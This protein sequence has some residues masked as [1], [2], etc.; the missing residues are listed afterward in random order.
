MNNK[1]LALIACRPCK[2]WGLREVDARHRGLQ[3]PIAILCPARRCRCSTQAP[4]RLVAGHIAAA[5]V[6]PSWCGAGPSRQPRPVAGTGPNPNPPSPR[7]P[8]LPAWP[9]RQA[10]PH[11]TPNRTHKR[12]RVIAGQDKRPA[13]GCP[14]WGRHGWAQLCAGS[15]HCSNL[16]PGH[17]LN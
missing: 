4:Q 10:R 1:D 2:P 14:T 9:A 13:A 15:L 7:W 12:E 11:H 6:A 8:A 16:A 5:R 3:K 17:Q